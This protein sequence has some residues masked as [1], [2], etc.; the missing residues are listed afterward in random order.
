[1]RDGVV[2]NRPRPQSAHPT[3]WILPGSLHRP[4]SA[5]P[6][7]AVRSALS[8]LK[9]HCRSRQKYATHP[10]MHNTNTRKATGS[11]GAI[12]RATHTVG[13]RHTQTLLV[14]DISRVPIQSRAEHC[15]VL[16][17]MHCAICCSVHDHAQLNLCTRRT[18]W[19]GLTYGSVP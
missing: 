8:R 7:P 15:A 19:V 18:S 13:T 5:H 10:F 17:R 6:N 14:H 1:M 2:N 9:L 4:I 3:T 11:K 12:K 16:Y